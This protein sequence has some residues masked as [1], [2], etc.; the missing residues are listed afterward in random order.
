[1]LAMNTHA[2][3]RPNATAALP[4][5]FFQGAS[6]HN[7]RQ[8]VVMRNIAIVAQ[9]STVLVVYGG[10]SIDLPVFALGAVIAA[11]ALFNLWTW[12][13]VASQRPASDNELCVQLLVDVAALALLLGLSGG[14]NNPFV[15]MFVLPLTI[16]A[17]CL[18]SAYTWVVALATVAAYSV[19][20]LVHRPLLVS[21][22]EAAHMR[23]LVSGIWVNYTISAGMIAHFVVR[24]AS[25]L[26]Q[27]HMRSAATR[28]REIENEHLVRI[29]TLAAGAAH[30]LA[31]PLST[32][33]LILGEL[34]TR[35]GDEHSVQQMAADLSQ[36]LRNCQET[37]GAL[38]S[39][40]H[41]AIDSR[42]ESEPVDVFVGRCM[43]AFNARRPGAQVRVTAATPGP[44]P[45]LAHD[46]ALRQAVLNL[47]GN[48]A[49]ASSRPIDLRIGWDDDS[50]SIEIRDHGPGL[51]AEVEDRI[52][53]LFFTTKALGSGN[54]LGVYLAQ[55][56]V[57]RLGGSLQLT[58]AEGGGAL[59]RVLL[60]IVAATPPD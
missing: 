54:G 11:L 31:Q 51:S 18:P 52:G 13:R 28:E 57:M 34:Q 25:N 38:L 20:A 29:G 48:A 1:M 23:L 5:G 46:L 9:A 36:Q 3:G 47:L 40:G 17:A 33:R 8:L 39:Y 10:L 49:D 44:T 15:G 45:R 43:A 14:A 56:A 55:V 12:R 37:L 42:L 4:P 21:G 26:R 30:E 32:M 22:D 60:P 7:L 41:R 50:I 24:I 19:L 2:I 59:A 53:E 27:A 35:R 16:T 58:N 6:L